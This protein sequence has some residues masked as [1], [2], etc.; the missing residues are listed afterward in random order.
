MLPGSAASWGVL[1]SP[2]A[3]LMGRK[4]MDS[5]YA[6]PTNL[7]PWLGGLADFAVDPLNFLSMGILTKSGL[8]GKMLKNLVQAH[9][10]DIARTTGIREVSEM[11]QGLSKGDEAILG[12]LRAKEIP[13]SSL[14]LAQKA[15]E[16]LAPTLREQADRGQWALARFGPW[17]TPK[18][19]NVRAANTLS[20]NPGRNAENSPGKSLYQPLRQ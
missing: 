20:R 12:V 13:E 6:E 5:S 15:S 1:G 19:V 2:T 9:G 14:T 10:D 3:E 17:F 4:P 18:S 7:T 11:V 8:S 16:Y